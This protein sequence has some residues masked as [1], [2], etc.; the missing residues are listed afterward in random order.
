MTGFLLAALALFLLALG[1]LAWRRDG[2]R[3]ADRDDP[4][5]HWY[6]QRARELGEGAGHG[7]NE[8]VDRG[9]EPGNEPG[10]EALREEARLRLLEDTL[11]DARP[12]TAADASAAGLGRVPLLALGAVLLLLSAA[13]YRHTGALEDVLI[14]RDLARLKPGAGTLARARLMERIA[15]RSAARE[16]NLQYLHLLGQLHMADENYRA[17]SAHFARLA[18][19]APEDPRAQAM[20]AQARFLAADRV[21]DDRA[22]LLAERALAVDP[23]QR[24]ALGLL[25]MAAFEAGSYRAAASYWERLQAQETPASPAYKM[26]GDVLALARQRGGLAAPADEAAL[27]DNTAAGGHSAGISVSLA[28]AEGVAAE[29]GAT[30]FV[31]ARPASARGGMPIAVRRLSAGDLPLTL[32]LSDA[33]SMAGQLLSAAGAVRVSAQLS[34]NGQPGLANARLSGAAGPV[35][36]GGAEASVTIVLGALDRQS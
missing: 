19:R 31:F 24:T 9:N 16:D 11:P 4:N 17:A 22:R 6:R 32:R 30:V 29:P 10:N 35:A 26:L 15:A 3:D 5:L 18:A 36:V 34:V 23:R 8:G 7:N 14:H 20:A 28:F 2:P 1:M 21:L 25:G 12:A 33:D 13:I 27:L